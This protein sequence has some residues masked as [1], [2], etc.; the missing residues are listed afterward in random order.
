MRANDR[1]GRAGPGEETA[2]VSIERLRMRRQGKWLLRG[3]DWRIREGEQWVILGPN[4]AGKTSL[5]NALAGLVHPTSGEIRVFQERFG[6]GDWTRLRDRIGLVNATVADWIEGEETPVELVVGGRYHQ[7]NYW[8]AWKEA[9]RRD[10]MKLRRRHGLEGCAE[11]PW[12]ILSQG[13][14]Q[15]TLICRALMAEFDL[16]ILDEPCAG[17]DPVARA[18][19]L[20]GVDGLTRR[21]ESDAATQ[22]AL[23][24]VTHHVEEIT[25]GFTHVLLLKNGRVF[26]SGEKERV[27]SSELLSEAYGADLRV[28]RKRDGFQLEFPESDQRGETVSRV[29]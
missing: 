19:F 5:L 3:I 11:R 17:L 25:P 23:I 1:A 27:L 20:H 29:R 12:R 22:P 14:R 28:V 16:L 4:G 9:D 2:W 6:E 24:L 18:S 10:A 7:V 21:D 26:A 13:E 15:R 8:G